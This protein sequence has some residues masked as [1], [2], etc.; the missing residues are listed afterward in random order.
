MSIAPVALILAVLL[1]A[2]IS[3]KTMRDIHE[4][5]VRPV[6]QPKNEAFAIW[7]LLFVLGVVHG[8]MQITS[9]LSASTATSSWWYA[10][11]FFVSALWAP[12]YFM[13]W[14]V[15]CVALLMVAWGCA[16]TSVVVLANSPPGW[17]TNLY[18]VGPGML[19][20]WLSLAMLLSLVLA[21]WKVAD[22]P[23]TLVA[24]SV[25]AATIAV[26]FRQPYV[27]IPVLWACLLHDG[28]PSAAL[29]SGTIAVLGILAGGIRLF[30]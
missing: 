10:A 12:C 4:P 29:R 27:C 24:A 14:Y 8:G 22:H 23:G 21:G 16:L 5:E 13:K 11:S 26:V 19:L 18:R 9:T 3:T 30:E 15:V 28:I 6:F 7:G 2:S 25:G 20:G 1:C 17:K